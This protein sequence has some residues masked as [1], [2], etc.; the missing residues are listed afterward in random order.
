MLSALLCASSSVLAQEHY[1]YFFMQKYNDYP[2]SPS[3]WQKTIL[4]SRLAFLKDF[5]I[6]SH[7]FKPK[8][9]NQARAGKQELKIWEN[10]ANSRNGASNAAA[11]GFYLY[12]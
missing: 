4:E 6:N 1:F 10:N 9:K 11:V 2:D 8:L 12:A 7:D 5:Y 3:F